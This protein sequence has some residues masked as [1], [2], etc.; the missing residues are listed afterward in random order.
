MQALN[1]GMNWHCIDW[2]IHSR[3]LILFCWYFLSL[4][5]ITWL[6][7]HLSYSIWWRSLYTS[8]SFT[9]FFLVSLHKLGVGTCCLCI[10]FSDKE[11]YFLFRD[12]IF[13][14][15]CIKSCIMTYAFFCYSYTVCLI[16][17][18]KIWIYGIV[19]F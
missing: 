15:T 5:Y 11:E 19:Y 4:S 1:P 17:L 9:S 7:S 3:A 14:L 6:R 2:F 13:L 12:F 8:Y 10:I 18:D 16:S